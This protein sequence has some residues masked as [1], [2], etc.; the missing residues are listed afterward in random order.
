M[1]NR[2]K[3]Y[4]ALVARLILVG[5]KK[6][7][8]SKTTDIADDIDPPSSLWIYLLLFSISL[9]LAKVSVAH[10]RRA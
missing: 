5:E 3:T 2:Q 10:K 4:E 6:R 9:E 7:F 1:V 8:L